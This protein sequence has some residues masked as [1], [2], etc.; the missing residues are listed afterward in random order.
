[1]YK[2][3][4]T[5]NVNIVKEGK[6]M[7]KVIKQEAKAEKQ[8]LEQAVRDLAELQK[9]QKY[10]IKVRINI[11]VLSS[12]LNAI[13]YRRRLRPTLHMLKLCAFSTRKNSPTLPLV[14]GSRELKPI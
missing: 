11:V 5:L 10:A 1:V 3:G 4:S 2:T 12:G 6:R 7:A 8:A 13:V 9:T 14:P